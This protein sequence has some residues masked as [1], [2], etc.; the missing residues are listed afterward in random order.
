[1]RNIL[2]IIYNI[3]LLPFSLYIFNS[4]YKKDNIND[5]D[6]MIDDIIDWFTSDKT[7]KERISNNLNNLS[8]N[9]IQ[10]TFSKENLEKTENS[11]KLFSKDEE[12]QKKVLEDFEKNLGNNLNED[13]KRYIKND[14]LNKYYKE[15]IEKK[16]GEFKERLQIEI[17]KIEKEKREQEIRDL[18][19]RVYR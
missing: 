19:D 11:E 13:N 18:N 3:F 2:Y 8:K 5:I 15:E 12:V 6:L 16:K 9:S 1:M 4:T 10:E 14:E 17:D 7:K